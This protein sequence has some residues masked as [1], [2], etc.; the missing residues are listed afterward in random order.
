[1]HLLQRGDSSVVHFT[2]SLLE[3]LVIG[4]YEKLSAIFE[5]MQLDIDMQ[6]EVYVTA[7]TVKEAVL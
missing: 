2:Q 1:M 6:E 3:C 7:R 4:F 5:G